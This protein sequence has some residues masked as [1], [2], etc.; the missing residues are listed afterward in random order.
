MSAT[1]PASRLN[2]TG[3]SAAC[4]PERVF[5][6]RSPWIIRAGRAVRFAVRSL[7]DVLHAYQNARR[8]ERLPIALLLLRIRVKQF[9]MKLVPSRRFRSEQIFDWQVECLDYNS[10]A[11]IVE[12]IFLRGDYEF[13]SAVGN[14]L[15]FDCGSNIG[16]ALFGFKR[17]YPTARVIAF[18]PSRA[19]YDVL[20]RNVKAN[21]LEGVELHNLALSG[22]AAEVEFFEDKD[23]PGS[24]K[25]SIFAGR[26][27]SRLCIVQAVKLSQFLTEPVDMLKLDIE[28]AEEDVLA[29]LA[30]SGRLQFVRQMVMEY[31]HHVLPGQDRLSHTLR[32]LED[33]GFSYEFRGTVAQAPAVGGFQDLLIHAYRK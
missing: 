8:E 15:I 2:P 28:G 4:P 25:N 10:L 20:V 22:S 21:E 13:P 1:A 18:E 31:H 12:E 5:E 14:P 11:F 3:Q 33:N 17:R 32:I 19:T 24:G 16:L 7:S 30:Q 23:F 27:G 9:W 26:G 6:K 29:E